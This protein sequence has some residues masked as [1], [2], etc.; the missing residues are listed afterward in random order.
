MSLSAEVGLAP[1][2]GDGE[3]W[4][5]D[6]AGVGCSVV[7]GNFKA[8]LPL[9]QVLLDLTGVLEV[10]VGSEQLPCL[11][12]DV[13]PLLLGVGGVTCPPVPPRTQDLAVQTQH[14]PPQPLGH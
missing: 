12:Q 1:G 13:S 8:R 4:H 2:L 3:R 6:R 14:L 5:V 11:L 9:H 7:Q 10:L